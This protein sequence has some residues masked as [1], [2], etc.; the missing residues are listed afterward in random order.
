MDQ[1]GS[2]AEIPLS[3]IRRESHAESKNETE[4]SNDHIH[5]ALAVGTVEQ[6]GEDEVPSKKPLSFKLAFIGLAAAVFVF[7]ID[8]TSL[9]TALPVSSFQLLSTSSMCCLLC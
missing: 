7:Q 3:T 5:E 2:S 1:P 4:N 9:G 8:A 6:D